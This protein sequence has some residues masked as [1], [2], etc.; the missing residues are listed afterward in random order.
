[1]FFRTKIG[2]TKLVTLSRYS[3]IFSDATFILHPTQNK[4][5]R[6]SAKIL[7]FDTMNLLLTSVS[8]ESS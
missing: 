6:K 8:N 7:A 4:A 2:Q 3:T 1:M 5:E